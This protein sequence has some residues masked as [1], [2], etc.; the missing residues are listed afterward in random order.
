M[1]HSNENIPESLRLLQEYFTIAA[2]VVEG[3]GSIDKFFGGGGVMAL[4]NEPRPVLCHA[5]AACMAALQWSDEWKR[6]LRG[7]VT[8]SHHEI[9]FGINTGTALV[10]NIGTEHRFTYTAMGDTVNLAHRLLELAFSLNLYILV[11][12]GTHSEVSRPFEWR[13]LGSHQVSGRNNKISV[14][15]LLGT[16]GTLSS[17]LLQA[18]DQFERGLAEQD[19]GNPAEARVRFQHALELRPSDRLTLSYLKELD[20]LT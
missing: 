9:R 3:E 2:K 17:D 10:G 15:E 7:M 1:I 20:L 6:T 13:F 19:R 8:S 12:E 11:G 14:W 4:F 18:R 5:D 16:R